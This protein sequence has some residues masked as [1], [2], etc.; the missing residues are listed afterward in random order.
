MPSKAVVFRTAAGP[1]I[2]LGHLTRMMTMASALSPELNTA[3]FVLDGDDPLV[4]EQVR[5]RGF[6]VVSKGDDVCE[7]IDRLA[8]AHVFYDP[9]HQDWETSAQDL[10]RELAEQHR[11]RR[12]TVLFDGRG[13]LAYRKQRSPAEVSCIVVPYVGE[14]PVQSGPA[15]SIL[16]GPAYFPLPAHY[17][18]ETPK[19]I[20]EKI[21]RVLVTCGGSDPA[22]ATPLLLEAVL[23]SSLRD[24]SIVVV[25]G[26]LFSDENRARVRAIAT[27]AGGHIT[28]ADAPAD[29]RELQNA[30]DLCIC[31]NGLTKYELAYL[32]IPTIVVSVSAEN[33][34]ANLKFVETGA[35]LLA[36]SSDSVS[37]DELAGVI[38]RVVADFPARRAMHAAART[39]IDG[40]GAQ[41]ILEHVGLPC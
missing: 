26:S 41:R 4:N 29:L 22:G 2:G 35:M 12:H 36:G 19:Q 39:L 30:V 16:A 8:P 38:S 31:G 23:A 10:Y 3:T 7:T 9:V 17:R 32:G 18:L 20:N 24:V 21:E 40:R 27:R 15:K 33:H 6:S 14:S 11:N 1:R 37:V 28:I 5:A 13:K 34:A 25:L